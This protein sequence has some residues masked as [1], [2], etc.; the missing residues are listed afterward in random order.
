MRW[1][2]RGRGRRLARCGI[3]RYIKREKKESHP[4]THTYDEE[5]STEEMSAKGLKLSAC[6]C[7]L[8]RAYRF[9]FS[10][11]FHLR[12]AENTQVLCG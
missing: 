10:C 2:R 7:W 12:Q 3:R 4:N 9:W 11:V 8:Q 1:R 6:A 5:G